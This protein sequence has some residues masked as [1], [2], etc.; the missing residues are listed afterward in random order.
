MKGKA[1][2]IAHELKQKPQ[3]VVH[4]PRKPWPPPQA[5]EVAL[6]VDGYLDPT[7]GSAGSGMILRDMTG[8]VIFASYRKLFHCNEA[9]E[10]ELQAM[11]E[12]LKLAVEHSQATIL[13]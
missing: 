7:D 13:I 11:M 9:L 6:S 10:V 5:N 2:M 4:A 3:S 12:G 1:P 8:A